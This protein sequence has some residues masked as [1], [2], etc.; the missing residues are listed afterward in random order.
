M[1]VLPALVG[2]ANYHFG[3]PIEPDASYYVGGVALFPSPLG[4]LLGTAGGYSGLAVLNAAASFVV[5]LSIGLIARELGGQPL[6]AQAVALLIARGEWFNTWGMDSPGVALLLLAAL[7]QFRGRSR[8]AVVFIGLAA[9]THLAA[10]PLAIGAL[11]MHATRRSVMAL[12]V[13]LTAAGTAVAYFTGYRAGFEVLHEPRALMEGTQEL[14]TA[15]WPLLLLACVA[16]FHPRIR[17]IFVG[18]ALGAILAGAIPASVNQLNITRYAVPCIFI[19]AAG[20]RL[21]GSL[22]PEKA[23]SLLTDEVAQGAGYA[24]GTPAVAVGARSR[25]P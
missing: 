10:L 17:L 16:T 4:T 3:I 1:L 25:C 21:R 15:C 5:I 8:W 11:L 19:A 14:V 24:P 12:V 18:S 2:G 13:G 22:G 7:F 6:V 9:A 20:V 23:E